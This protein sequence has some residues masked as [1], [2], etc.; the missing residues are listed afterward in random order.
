MNNT[1][2]EDNICFPAIKI[3]GCQDSDFLKI[4]PY[5]V[6]AICC[7]ALIIFFYG[8]AKL[9]RI[10][11]ARSTIIGYHTFI[12]ISLLFIVQSTLVLINKAPIPVVCVVI[13]IIPAGTTM[14]QWFFA[15][16]VILLNNKCSA[17][18]KNL[19]G[20]KFF[21]FASKSAVRYAGY[22]L[23][24]C[25]LLVCFI[26]FS[27]PGDV[28]F[29]LYC[30]IF[31]PA[32]LLQIVSNTGL[33]YTIASQNAIKYLL[34]EYVSTTAVL[35]D[36]SNHNSEGKQNRNEIGT[37]L[38]RLSKLCTHNIIAALV[39]NVA[40][41]YAIIDFERILHNASVRIFP[42]ILMSV[43]IPML[44]V[45]SAVGF[46][47]LERKNIRIKDILHDLQ[48]PN[49]IVLSSIEIDPK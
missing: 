14:F 20:E 30:G 42:W 38:E 49:S 44:L 3:F 24:L 17:H 8:L 28:A 25:E 19:K 39:M 6:L 37:T 36:G 16:R 35:S 1:T 15:H 48:L 47:L 4:G 34:H 5:V 22:F 9:P 46:Y 12:T 23:L 31:I 43:C 33:I 45:G 10:E 40:I 7:V 41:L 26:G 21:K 29:Q 2:T 32:I 18:M 13:H 27:K 11:G